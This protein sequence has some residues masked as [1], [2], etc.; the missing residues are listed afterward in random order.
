MVDGYETMGKAKAKFTKLSD[1]ERSTF[2][3]VAYGLK[4]II[5]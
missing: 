2:R 1:D 5:N 3:F 4:E